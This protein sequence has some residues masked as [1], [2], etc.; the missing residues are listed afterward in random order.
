MELRTL[1]EE[2]EVLRLE[3]FE[4]RD[5]GEDGRG[6]LEGRREL[7]AIGATMKAVERGERGWKRPIE[8]RKP[9]RVGFG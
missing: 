6:V 1:L 9:R 3:F 4:G 2:R 8:K 7:E 5:V